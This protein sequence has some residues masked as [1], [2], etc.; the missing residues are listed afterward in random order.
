MDKKKYLNYGITLSMIILTASGSMTNGWLTLANLV[1]WLGLIGTIS[2]A[3]A[4]KWNFPFNMSQNVFAAV[5]GGKSKLYG[6]MFMSIFFFLSQVYGMSNWKKH[7]ING[8]IKIEQK[9]NWSVVGISIV[10][11]FVLLGSISYLMGGTFILLDALNN[12]TAIVAQVLQMRREKSSWILWMLTNLIGIIIW[13]GVGVPQMAIM[14]GVFA[15]NS[16]RGYI[17]WS[18]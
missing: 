15:L 18:E 7:T 14:Y 1:S 17:N 8:K 12:S 10:I 9:S 5:Q 3:Y 6:D 16:V 2:L 11:G 4:K 13:L